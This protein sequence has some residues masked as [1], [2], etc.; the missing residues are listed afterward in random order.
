M[1]KQ[2][3]LISILSILL[4]SSCVTISHYYQVYK[5]VP[6][7]KIKLQDN[8]LVYE[9]ENCQVSYNLWD[10][11]GNAGFKM[12]N[13]TDKN[14]YLNLE[15]SFF[16]INGISYDYYK[17]RTF[18]NSK[19]TGMATTKSATSSSSML[20]VN[21]SS[22]QVNRYSSTNVIG[23]TTSTGYSESLGEKKM[24]IIPP[25][26]AK[27][28]S[29][30][31]IN[32]SLIR[33]CELFKFPSKKQIITK[34]YSKSESPLIFSNR[35]TYLTENSGGPIRFENEFFISEITNYPEGEMFSYVKDSY[36]NQKSGASVKV[37]K[38]SSADKFYIRYN[39]L[40]R[41]GFRH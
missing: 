26:S 2:L 34:T 30:Y 15:E 5:T 29:E 4:S 33:N 7:G 17:E 23:T 37:F 25:H 8:Q 6:D 11:G 35:I 41:D 28:I 31:L 20:L 16:I 14:L 24:Q 40:R 22:N 19:T 1:K 39:D 36:C 13:K 32:E 18:T 21:T 12:F 9:D 10:E 27:I 3:F 38:D